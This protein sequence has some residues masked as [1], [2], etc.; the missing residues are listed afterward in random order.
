M[1]IGCDQT[2]GCC[3]VRAV[4]VCSA[5]AAQPLC[6]HSWVSLQHLHWLEGGTS[7][8][9]Q[10]QHSQQLQAMAP[11]QLMTDWLISEPQPS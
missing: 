10:K 1:W 8:D 3:K 4:A 11:Q 6:C 9:Q 7:W 2:R 5:K